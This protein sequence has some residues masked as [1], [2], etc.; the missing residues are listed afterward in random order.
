ML[1]YRGALLTEDLEGPLASCKEFK[2][3]RRLQSHGE[4]EE[5]QEEGQQGKG[6][7]EGSSGYS[8]T[9]NQIRRPLGEHNHILGLNVDGFA[10][11]SCYVGND[12]LGLRSHVWFVDL[13]VICPPH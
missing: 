2:Q 6:N 7:K 9:C 5:G 10:S 12:I 13:I 8:S 4:I 1:A 11:H 3:R